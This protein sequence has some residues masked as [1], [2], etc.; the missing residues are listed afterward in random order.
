ME[1]GLALDSVGVNGSECMRGVYGEAARKRHPAL[2]GPDPQVG[3]ATTAVPRRGP[4]G[5]NGKSCD[6]SMAFKMAFKS[7]KAKP[8]GPAAPGI[9]PQQAPQEVA[10]T[11]AFR[12]SRL[13]DTGGTRKLG[14]GE[15]HRNGG[16]VRT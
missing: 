10:P 8:A 7:V 12:S 16:S 2:E 14:D 15:R 4:A 11:V 6:K 9:A 13:A 5:A 3:G 1:E